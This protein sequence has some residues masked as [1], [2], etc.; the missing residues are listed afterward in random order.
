MENS[1]AGLR[2]LDIGEIDQVA[3]GASFSYDCYAGTETINASAFGYSFSYTGFSGG[4][5]GWGI[6]RGNEWIVIRV[7]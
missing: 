2:T 1:S 4:G 6:S 5:G 3:G 7:F